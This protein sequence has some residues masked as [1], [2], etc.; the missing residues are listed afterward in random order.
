MKPS[1]TF[2]V[3]LSS[4]L[5]I[6]AVVFLLLQSAPTS[7]GLV[8][9]PKLMAA[10]KA[11][12]QQLKASGAGVPP[13]VSLERLIAQGLLTSNDVTGFAG[14]NVSVTLGVDPQNLRQVLMRARLPDGTEIAALNDGS[15]QQMGR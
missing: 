10:A 5:A 3:L 8:D 4:V 14:M 13:E 6:G 1:R 7:T 11:Y 9:V 2:W 15:V 12:A